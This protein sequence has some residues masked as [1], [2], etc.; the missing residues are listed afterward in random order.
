[1]TKAEMK[2]M[3]AKK[4]NTYLRN[5]GNL[6]DWSYFKFAWD[7]KKLAK[8]REWLDEG[9]LQSPPPAGEQE[10]A[11]EASQEQAQAKEPSQDQAPVARRGI[12]DQIEIQEES[13]GC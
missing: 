7:K 4:D 2:L 12:L 3:H 13:A 10:E 8:A 1:M 9:A 5:G 6:D 11:E